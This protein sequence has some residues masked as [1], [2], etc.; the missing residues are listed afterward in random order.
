[1]PL[2]DL[3]PGDDFIPLEAPATQAAPRLTD[4]APNEPVQGA[5][6]GT[7]LPFSRDAQGKTSF[8]PFNAGL[9]A[10]LVKSGYAAAR[11][12]GDVATGKLPI[13]TE[14]GQYNPDMVN[15]ATDFAT[16][17]A[18]SPA[19]GGMPTRQL[20]PTAPTATE[21]QEAGS[22][23]YNAARQA[24]VEINPQILADTASRLTNDLTRR[25]FGAQVAPKTHA[26][27]EQAATPPSGPGVLRTLTTIDDLEALRRN[28]SEL[29][30][31]GGSEGGAARGAIKGVDQILERLTPADVVAGTAA[32]NAAS[33]H[34]NPGG[35]FD[36]H[37]N[38]PAGVLYA[39]DM[40][41]AQKMAAQYGGPGGGAAPGLRFTQDQLDALSQ[42]QRDARANYAAGFRVNKLNGELDRAN[43]GLVERADV[44]SGATY[45]GLNF[46]NRLRQN[47]ASFLEK[48]ANVR[49]YSDAEIE[50]LNQFVNPGFGLRNATRYAGNLLGGGGGLGAGFTGSAATALGSY[51]TGNPA[52]G[53]AIG[54]GTPALGYGLKKGQN[55][56]ASNALGNIEEMI[57]MRSPLGAERAANAGSVPDL[58]DI[59]ALRLLLLG[60]AQSQPLMPFGLSP[61]QPSPSPGIPRA[62]PGWI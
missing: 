23:G 61:S 45:S 41:Q 31:A 3:R 17:F 24:G 39:T 22:A 42:T 34:P 16:M 8:D 36:I 62:T 2:V 19:P 32:A 20:A 46:D 53:M 49:G 7:V 21:L 51:L 59:A 35:G 43:T 40:A 38:G 29:A 15:R 13:M 37:T 52:A 58:R 10:A 11:A 4:L 18:A 56:L 5:Y 33:I 28:F 54:L 12:P 6:H 25:G 30:G 48:P 60:G 26:L 9:L 50:A 1:M 27:L 55:A 14:T 47:V 44:R 57:A